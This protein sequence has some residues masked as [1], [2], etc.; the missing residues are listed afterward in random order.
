MNANYRIKGLCDTY[1][2]KFT[3]V[4]FIAA[5]CLLPF[6]AHGAVNKEDKTVR[7]I[8]SQLELFVD[9]WL[10]ESMSN[11]TLKLHQPIRKEIVFRFDAPWEG[12][13]SGYVT[14]MKDDNRFRMYYRGGGDLSREYTCLAESEDGINWKRPSLGLFEL[15]GSKDNNI[16]WTGSKK[17]YYESHNFSPFKDTNTRALPDHRYKAITLSRQTLDSQNRKVL[18]AFVSP[19]GIHWQRLREEPIITEGSFDSHNTAFW[20][21]IQQTYVCYSRVSRDGKRS[22]QRCV[23][24]DFVHWSKPQLLD[25]GNTPIEHLYTNGILPYIRAPHI[26]L[27][28]AMRFVPERTQVGIQQRRTDGLSDAVLLSSHDGLHWNRNFMEAF[29]RPGLDQV[30]WGGAHGNNTPAWGIIQTNEKEMSLYITENYGNYPDQTDCIPVLRRAT[31]RTDGF[32]SVNTPYSSGE[33]ITRPL[34]F[35]GSALIIN[36]STSAVGFLKVEIQDKNGQPIPA[37]TLADATEI[38]G[39]EIERIVSWKH[40][41]DVSKLAGRIIKLRFVMKD[42]DLYST[43]FSP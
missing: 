40:G 16:I 12:A 6:K 4:L 8:G 26:Y 28:F 3:V 30:N 5:F 7:E 9:D 41:T 34:I 17:S 38:Y 43:R 18:M 39:D 35:R 42:A 23:S 24:P 14:I 25:F 19:D 33:M 32:V 11:T 1:Y 21:T 15:N 31:I 37:F 29:I 22:I 13:Q 27:A 2:I 10:I 36:Y 20:D